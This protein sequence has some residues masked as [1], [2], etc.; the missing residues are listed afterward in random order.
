MIRQR[1]SPLS[2]HWL[3]R[4]LSALCLALAIGVLTLADDYPASAAAVPLILGW[5][6]I[7]CAIGLWLFPGH[8]SDTRGIV[9][10]RLLRGAAILALA[11]WL[12]TAVGADAGLWALFFGCAWLMGQ[13]PNAKLA[14]VAL[15]F[16]LGLGVLFGSLLGV[17][18]TGPV[19][20]L[21]LD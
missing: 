8:P 14:L 16:T 9:A 10:T 1:L 12:F 4:V 21:F 18:L 17:P 7:P 20:G 2:G 13:S 5:L 15:L 3:D 19:F 6:L 11:C